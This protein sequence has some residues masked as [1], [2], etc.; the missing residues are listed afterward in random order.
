MCVFCLLC[1]HITSLIGT[2]YG[3]CARIPILCPNYMR[4]LRR[5]QLDICTTNY[6]HAANCHTRMFEALRTQPLQPL[7][8]YRL[9]RESYVRRC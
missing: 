5:R 7:V 4:N 1:R 9:K 2:S 3:T 8:V 6:H